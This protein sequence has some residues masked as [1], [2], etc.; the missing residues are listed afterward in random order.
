[1][2]LRKLRNLKNLTQADVAKQLSI[3][4]QAY[5]NY[6]RGDRTPDINTCKKLSEIFNV[7]LEELIG[8]KK[9]DPKTQ[10]E[11]EPDFK[12][13]TIVFF[14]RGKGRKEFEVSDSEMEAWI[15]LIETTKNLKDNND[16]NF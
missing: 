1:M 8:E 7:S 16:G 15:K 12:K 5:A 9:L 14:G 2:E 4:P 10:L 6:E 13:N 3:T 11:Q